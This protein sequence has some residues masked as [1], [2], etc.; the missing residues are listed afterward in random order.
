[1]QPVALTPPSIDIA[2]PP[3]RARLGSCPSPVGRSARHAKVSG[4][5]LLAVGSYTPSVRLTNEDLRSAVGV[6]DE[7]VLRRTGIG[8]RRHALTHQA[9]SDLCFHAAVRCLD[10]AGVTRDQVDLLIV[11]T[12]TPDMA[13]PSTAC[14]LQDRLGLSCGA[15]DLQAGCSG[16]IYALATGAQFVQSGAAKRCL[17]VGGDTA[18]RI[19]NPT[20]RE[21][22]PLF[23]D[24]AGVALLGPCGPGQGMVA[25]QLGSDGSGAELL[26]RHGSGS[27]SHF[28]CSANDDDRQYVHMEGRAVFRWAVQTIEHSTREL[29]DYAGV[30][31]PDIDLFIPHQANI[32]LVE[33]IAERLGFGP[34]RVYTNLSRYGNTIA[35]SI[36]LALDEAVGEGRVNRGD[37]VLLT[38]FGAGLTW[39]SILFR[40]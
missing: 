18:S 10:N 40:W 24:G 20:D 3:P 2:T 33:A 16:F 5:Q 37:L 15:F 6:D 30:T 35:A 19:I 27:R 17:I 11:A 13:V 14:L 36:P 28:G 1:M 32:R 21:T 23:G 29:L 22:Y 34:E 7:W 4:V 12:V 26:Y 9:T 39:G 25:F 38:G 8:E 31:L